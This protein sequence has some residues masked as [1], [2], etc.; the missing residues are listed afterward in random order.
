[1]PAAP[2]EGLQCAPLAGGCLLSPRWRQ[3]AARMRSTRPALTR[4]CAGRAGAGLAW[5]PLRSRRGQ[6]STCRP[7]QATQPQHSRWRPALRPPLPAPGAGPASFRGRAS[8][9]AIERH[10]YAPGHDP[11]N[12]WRRRTGQWCR[13]C[14]LGTSLGRDAV[15]RAASPSPPSPRPHAQLPACAGA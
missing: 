1:M 10:R 9:W 13:P 6:A 2:P 11:T 12:A 5:P 3:L 7:R 15:A 4:P 8:G 14:G